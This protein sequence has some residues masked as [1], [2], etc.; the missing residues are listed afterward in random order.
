MR[1]FKII[2]TILLLPALCVA[3]QHHSGGRSYLSAGL[4]QIKESEN[5]G[6]VFSGPSLNYRHQLAFT[7]KNRI[8]M[9]E[10]EAG[11]AIPFSK[12]IPALHIHLKP[13][14]ISWLF[15]N[16][17]MNKNF[18]AGPMLK[19]EYDYTLYPQLQSAFDYWFTN[20]SLG[21]NASFAIPVTN[22]SCAVRVK[23]SVAGFTSRQ[24][25]YR[26]PYWYD[27]GVMH[28][29]RHLHSGLQFSPPGS[30]NTSS[31]ELTWEPH[32]DSR[33]LWTYCFSY[34]GYF[35]DPALSIIDHS[36]RLTWNKKK[37]KR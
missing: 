27:I 29:L 21:L 10:N 4:T 14:E 24:P 31:L 19:L 13:A 20:I 18:T 5:F 25:N 7:S 11:A 23:S 12:G 16:Q 30:Y 8:I 34:A 26:N 28:A 6:L 33:F 1:I 15:R 32:A 36:I 35:N 9:I 37:H 2:V 3:Q 22:H 17:K